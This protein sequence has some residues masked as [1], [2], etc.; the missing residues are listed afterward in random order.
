LSEEVGEILDQVGDYQLLKK[1]SYYCMNSEG[2]IICVTFLG[3]RDFQSGVLG[4]LGVFANM[5][6]TTG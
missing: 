4:N 2:N 3:N 1:K 5:K 6:H